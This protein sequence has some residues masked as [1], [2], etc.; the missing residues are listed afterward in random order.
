MRCRPSRPHPTPGL[1]TPGSSHPPLPLT[2]ED[3]RRRP[4]PP[5]RIETKPRTRTVDRPLT[6]TA[7]CRLPSRPPPTPGRRFPTLPLISWN[8]PL[9]PLLLLC[10]GPASC[11]VVDCVGPASVAPTAAPAADSGTRRA[12][13]PGVPTAA[14]RLRR[15]PRKE[16][17]RQKLF[18]SCNNEPYSNFFEPGVN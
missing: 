6:D 3:A 14:T 11:T 16:S 18:Y 5:V 13:P 12:P 4:T 15:A 10:P 17:R 7:M 9:G 1:R 8:A 2:L